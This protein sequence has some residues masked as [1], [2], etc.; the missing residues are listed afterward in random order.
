MHV[1]NGEQRCTLL[2]IFQ[3]TPGLNT[4]QFVASHHQWN[5][6][7]CF[8]VPITEKEGLIRLVYF[9]RSSMR[10]HMLNVCMRARSHALR[11]N[12]FC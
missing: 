4:C 5:P 6:T 3:T 9:V 1:E 8:Y 2:A 12:D 11:T 10:V 7:S